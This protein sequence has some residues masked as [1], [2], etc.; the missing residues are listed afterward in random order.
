VQT[1]VLLR[2]ITLVVLLAASTVLLALALYLLWNTSPWDYL[3]FIDRPSTNLDARAQLLSDKIDI[4]NHQIEDL[5]NV[6]ALLLILSAL[7]VIASTISSHFTASRYQSQCERAL[8]LV[9]YD[10]AQA[11]GDLREIREQAERAIERAAVDSGRV[12][13]MIRPNARAVPAAP[14]QPA[15]PQL[16][17]PAAIERLQV[18]VERGR[19]PGRSNTIELSECEHAL[20]AIALIAGPE[21][22]ALLAPV[23]RDLALYHDRR[24]PG[25][26]HFYRE[27]ANG[28]VPGIAPNS[29][30]EAWPTASARA[31][32]RAAAAAAGGSPDPLDSARLQY[33]MAVLNRSAGQLD[34]AEELLRRALEAARRDTVLA[35][36]IRYELACTHALR[37]PAHFAQALDY[38]RDA[39]RDK[40]PS[41]EKRISRD[42]DDG[43]A[44]QALAAEP[45]FDKAVNDLLLDVSV[46]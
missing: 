16:D 13:E 20:A 2:R 12:E 35:A 5:R 3:P 1:R 7:Y 33:N 31:E 45:P 43:G 34:D 36:E 29:T 17:I 14:L 4:Y 46:S 38:L 8:D 22:A 44:L 10:F 19:N 30:S 18:L 11:A 24:E 15:V 32:R 25:R 39:F 42:I 40:T 28:L 23:Y 26:A 37:G 9:H 27:R 21:H 6:V 41:I